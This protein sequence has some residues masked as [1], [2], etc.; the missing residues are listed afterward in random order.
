METTGSAVPKEKARTKAR[1]GPRLK[2]PFVDLK[3]Q[4]A[5]IAGEINSGIR[6]VL[7]GCDFILG[8]KVREFEER[9]AEYSAA[10]YNVGVASGTDAIHLALRALGVGPG[11]EVITQANTFMATPLAI[12]YT[13]ARPVF[14]DIAAETYSMDTEK[15][16]AAVTKKTRAIIPV[17][18]Y[19]RPAPMD[20]ITEI[21]D[22]YGLYVVEDACQAHG[23]CYYGAVG[24]RRT[25]SL[26]DAAAFSFY[27]GK[28]LGAYGDGGM[29]TTKE[30]PTF[31]KLLMLRDYGQE[32][33]HHHVIKGFNSRLD[34]LQ[35]AVLY[36]KLKHLD[37][38]NTIRMERAER[39]CELLG[40]V[41]EVR[42]PNFDPTRPL[43]HVFHLFVILAKER[44]ALMAFLSD[45]GIST[46]IHYPVPCHL[47]E[48]F[49]DLG[50]RPGDFPVTEGC[51][52]GIMSLPIFPEI[53]DEQVRY[54]ADAVREFY[55][56]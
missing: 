41:A 44:D 32:K 19:G 22:R 43:S 40:D 37:E 45:R 28:N 20:E 47:Q 55:G 8:G 30:R 4:Y 21:A 50:H 26:G 46:G 16:E 31:E 42:L 15:V 1:R 18:M 14:V 27:P 48:A 33:K 49:S 9:F 6:D 39:Y 38:W 11:D 23:A 35:A 53:K 52:A 29:V 24:M 2:V 56:R 25:G 54:V 51:A 3:T 34:T 36:A 12:S 7:A 10:S 5:T 13:G 17:H